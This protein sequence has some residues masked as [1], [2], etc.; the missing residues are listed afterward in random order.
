MYFLPIVKTFRSI[1][2]ITSWFPFLTWYALCFL[3]KLSINLVEWHV[4]SNT[5]LNI[6]FE[7]SIILVCHQKGI[8]PWDRF[9]WITSKLIF[10]CRK[11]SFLGA[12]NGIH[13]AM[14]SK[15][16]HLNYDMIQITNLL[17]TLSV[18]FQIKPSFPSMK[19]AET[20]YDPAQF[21]N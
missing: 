18:S 3:R 11:P 8:Q 13:I 20:Q 5:I 19:D 21:S 12:I 4:S 2:L 15:L 17:L 1:C 10:I 14:A 7:F 6:F 9:F 16:F